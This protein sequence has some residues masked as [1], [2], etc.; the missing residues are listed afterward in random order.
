MALDPILK[1]IMPQDGQPTAITVTSAAL[2]LRARVA[3]LEQ[4]AI[5]G[6]QLQWLSTSSI[7][8]TPGAACIQGAGWIKSSANIDKTGIS[9]GNNVWGHVYLYSSS[10]V[11]TVEVVTTAPAAFFGSA[12]QKTG[13]SSRR[14]LGSVRTNSS[15][16]LV[17]FLHYQNNRVM[18]RED[19]GGSTFRKLT[20]GSATT[21][22][23]V[24]VSSAVPVTSRVA[25]MRVANTATTTALSG[26]ADDSAA[27][28]P[29]AGIRSFQPASDKDSEHPLTSTQT[30]TYWLSAAPASGG[31]YID[32][33]GYIF[34]R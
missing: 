13:D 31:L 8:I 12:Y 15:G 20:A 17:N 1:D 22:T 2:A 19:I 29:A 27:G 32:V 5:V 34:E 26:T 30:L 16:A 7:R 4:T 3:S 18:Y 33:F 11:A 25:L 21:E 23:T 24:D 9:L 14:Y 10:G 28:P 6:L